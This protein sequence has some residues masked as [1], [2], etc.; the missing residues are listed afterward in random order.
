MAGEKGTTT[1]KPTI[2]IPP[3]K[4]QKKQPEVAFTY[5]SDQQLELPEA[6][7]PPIEP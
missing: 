7:A 2:K 1:R 5:D 3:Q 4:P 6:P